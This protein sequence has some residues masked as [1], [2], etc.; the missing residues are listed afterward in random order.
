M[1][2]RAEIGTFEKDGSKYHIRLIASIYEL[3]PNDAEK[4]YSCKEYPIDRKRVI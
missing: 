3:D 1:Y 4:I 2:H